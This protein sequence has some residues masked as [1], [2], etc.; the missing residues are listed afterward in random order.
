MVVQGEEL[1]REHLTIN[2][3]R[4]LRD[5]LF[6]RCT[7]TCPSRDREGPP[8]PHLGTLLVVRS[9]PLFLKIVQTDFRDGEILLLY[10]TAELGRSA[11]LI[12]I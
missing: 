6:L 8:R 7:A 4:N 11:E 2:V 9:I 5:D 3:Y 10:T 1:E 12:Y